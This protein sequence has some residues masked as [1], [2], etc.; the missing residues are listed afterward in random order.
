MIEKSYNQVENDNANSDHA[1]NC[2]NEAKR[3]EN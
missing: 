3:K 1:I 2:I